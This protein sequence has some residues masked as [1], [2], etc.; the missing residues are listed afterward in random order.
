MPKF[1]GFI[2]PWLFSLIIVY[3]GYKINFHHSVSNFDKVLDGTIVFSSIVVGFLSALLGILIS[4]RNSEIVR[5]IFEEKEKGTLKYYFYEAITLGFLVVGTS[6][7]MHVL[8]GT[9]ITVADIVFYIWNVL[10]VAFVPST[11][12][13]V[14]ILMSIFFKAGDTNKRPDGNDSSDLEKEERR[15]RLSKT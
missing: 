5:E 12:R 4:I 3:F 9:N 7:V 11:Y 2:Y 14:S 13:I 1:T 6:I 8:R 10:I 15:K